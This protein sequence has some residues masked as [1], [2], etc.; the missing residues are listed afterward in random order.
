MNTDKPV[1]GIFR[2]VYRLQS[3]AFIK[4]QASALSMFRPVMIGRDI[5]DLGRAEADRLR[6]IQMASTLLSRLFFTLFS[7]LFS[8]KLTNICTPKLIHAHFGP[9][10]AVALGLARR[11]KVPLVLTCHGFDVQRS[12]FDQF[13]TLKPTNLI[14]LWREKKLY[15]QANKIIAVSEFLKKKILDR[16]CPD[17]KIIVHY[18]GTDVSKFYPEESS[19][20]P[21][22]IVNIAR[23]I[24]LKGI[25][26]LLHAV[27]ELKNHWPS[28]KLLQVGTGPETASLMRLSESLGISD[29][30]QWL[31]GVGHSEIPGVFNRG[32]VYVHPSRVDPAGQTEAFGIVLIEAQAAGLPVVAS[33]SGGI[34][35]TLVDQETG[36]LFSEGDY[37]SLASHV[38]K[39]LSDTSLLAKMSAQ[40]RLHAIDKFCIKRQTKLLE[41]VYFNLLNTSQ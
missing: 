25:D 6:V 26:I 8:K 39:I 7:G 41:D 27:A 35:E 18:I 15:Q 9:D 31:G 30:V 16:G 13:K 24:N 32:T 36:F 17:E 2:T 40:A 33:K 12:R 21:F 11:L 37:I 38:S 5:T 28:V 1:V 4:E 29:N 10:G 23:H 14:F 19:R 22:T 20:E 3:E 34:P